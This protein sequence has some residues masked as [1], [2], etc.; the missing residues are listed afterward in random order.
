MF[1]TTDMFC[2]CGY[3]KIVMHDR[4][5]PPPEE[6]CIRCNTPMRIGFP[7]PT[8]MRAGFVDGQKRGERWELAKQAAKF[9]QESIRARKN[10]KKEESEFLKKESKELNKRA[11]TKRDKTDK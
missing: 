2:D 8:V 11:L 3:N 6:I 10:G 1:R 7:A 5:E 9:E 4:K